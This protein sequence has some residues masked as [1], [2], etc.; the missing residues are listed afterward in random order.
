MPITPNRLCLR[1]KQKTRTKYCPTCQAIVDAKQKEAK[2]RGDKYRPN[3]SKRG[4]D[5]NWN[6]ARKMYLRRFPLCARCNTLQRIAIA[7]LVHHIKPVAD[8]PELRLDPTNFMGLC[9]DCHEIIEG[10]KKG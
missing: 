8:Y 2:Q 4:Y 7:T 10:R 9:R 1:C 5:W 6:K 3:A